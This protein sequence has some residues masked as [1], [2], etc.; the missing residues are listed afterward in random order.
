MDAYDQPLLGHRYR[1][2]EQLGSGRMGTVYR[3]ADLLTGQIVALKRVLIPGESE[4]QLTESQSEQVRLAITDEFRTLATLRHPNVISVRDYGFDVDLRPFFT[5]DLLEGSLPLTEAARALSFADKLKLV[6]ALLEAL[7]YVHRRGVIHRDL[8]PANVQVDDAGQL[9]LLDFGLAVDVFELDLNGAT[10]S[11]FSGTVAYL[12]PE[13]LRGRVASHVSDLY[14]F[15]V[16]A[17]EVFTGRFPYNQANSRALIDHVLNRPPALDSDLIDPPL[18]LVIARLLSKD[19]DARYEDARSVIQALNRAANQPVGGEQLEIRESFLQASMFVGRDRDMGVLLLALGDAID[20]RGSAWL[21]G[22]E[23]GVGK[24]RLLEE[25]RTYALVK[26]ALVLRGQAVAEGGQSYHLWRAIVRRLAISTPLSDWEAGVLKALAPDI[27]TLLGREIPDAPPLSDASHENRLI[28]TLIALFQRQ[29]Q[30]IVLLLEDLHWSTASLEPLRQ[31]SALAASHSWLIVATYRLDEAPDLIHQ[32]PD[33]TPMRLARLDVQATGELTAAMLGSTRQLRGIVDVLYRETE[34]NPLFMVEVMRTLAEEAGTLEGIRDLPPGTRVFAG[35]VEQV[36]RRRLS[37]VPQWAQYGVKLAAV[38][39]RWLNLS[40]LFTAGL[41]ADLSEWLTVCADATVLELSD[42][43]WRFTHDLLRE[44]VLSDLAPE[45]MAELHRR[46]ASAIERLY[47]DPTIYAEEL[48]EHWAQSGEVVK[49]LHYTVIIATRW[50]HRTASYDMAQEFLE[51][52]LRLT[53]TSA[54]A[55]PYR[56]TLLKLLGDNYEQQG[57]YPQSATA[58]QNCLDEDRSDRVLAAEAFNGISRANWRQGNY[59]RAEYAAQQGLITARA[60]RHAAA[61]AASLNN[62]GTI[63]SNLHDFTS[64][65]RYYEE[66]LRLY[67]TIGNQQGE[68]AALTNLGVMYADRNDPAAAREYYLRSLAILRAIGEPRGTA[69]A[70]VNLAFTEITLGALTNARTSLAEAL[71]TAQ[72]IKAVLVLQECL[73]AAAR[74]SF[75]AGDMQRA[76]MLVGL[77]NASPA[78][79]DDVRLNILAPLVKELEA[80]LGFQEAT[81]AVWRGVRLDFAA[82]LQDVLRELESRGSSG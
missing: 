82:T 27:G 11:T 6:I 79:D 4:A 65:Q 42:G 40:I 57:L 46:V 33:L 74:L 36:L 26:G 55:R 45:E 44:T 80:A 38:A 72:A 13:R 5:M 12:A 3:A 48:A 14:A 43:V 10:S 20:G 22:G 15:G 71:R 29:T 8:K 61:I 51:R 56:A 23:S 1:L 7:A 28:L 41:N 47:P 64:A 59:A 52:G 32:L 77:A 69:N 35:G 81:A 39:G 2:I 75:V 66:S 67:Q 49:A 30:P 73:L 53:S 31:L 76:A 37:R 70:L 9:K 16:I 19:P 78:T 54:D 25:L 62:L 18:K 60:V 21:I 68:A 34:G 58:Y 50:V 63:R 24:S 17:Y